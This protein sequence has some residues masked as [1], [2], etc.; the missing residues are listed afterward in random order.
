MRVKA[1][2]P[3]IALA[4]ASDV[5]VG[6]GLLTAKFTATEVPPPGAGFVTETE[7]LPTATMSAAVI[8]AVTCVAL[9][10]VV[11]LALPLKLTVAPLTKPVPLTMRVKA[12]PPTVVPVGESVVI[13]GTGLLTAMLM[14]EDVPPPGAELNTVIGKDPVVAISAAVMAAVN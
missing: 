13:V 9:T 10:N 6:T 5:I 11:V 3:V 1:A 12:A 7:K 14:A 2:P 8:A 4:G